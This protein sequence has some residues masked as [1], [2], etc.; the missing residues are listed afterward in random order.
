M[1]KNE[2]DNI[3]GL[4]ISTSVVGI[5]V[6]NKHKEIIF[7][8]AIK[9][10]AN[11]DLESRAEFLQNTIQVID[12][13]WRINHVFVEQPFIAFSGGKTTAVTMSKLQR[14][15]GMCCYGIYSLYGNSPTLIQANKARGLVGIKVKRGQKAKPV[16]LEWV[17]DEYPDDFTYEMT[18]YG[19]PKPATFDMADAI[20]VARAGIELLNEENS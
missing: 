4:D 20:V 10:K 3:L 7:Y 12:S 18:K 11:M 19:N 14:F 1:D 6:L 5:A 9:F 17:K 13:Q 15:N 8:N 2:D 16:V